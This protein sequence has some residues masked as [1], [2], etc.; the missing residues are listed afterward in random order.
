MFDFYCAGFDSGFT[1]KQ[2]NTVWN[3]ARMA[4]IEEPER[5]F[6]SVPTINKAIAA[7]IALATSV[8]TI[9]TPKMQKFLE[10]V[11]EYRSKIELNPPQKQGLKN[12]HGIR[13][14]QRLRLVLPTHGIFTSVVLSN[15]GLITISYPV[16]VKDQ[17]RCFNWSKK[18][19]TV[20]FWRKNDAGYIF[21]TPVYEVGHYRGRSVLFL[22]HSDKLQRSQ[23]RKNIRCPCSIMADL[24]LLSAVTEADA[25]LPETDKGIKC[26]LED[27]SE[28]GALIR[29]GGKGQENMTIKIQ[30]MLGESMIVMCGVV[31]SV[32]FN[33]K[34]NQSRLHFQAENIADSVKQV[35]AMYVY[36]VIPSEQKE[37]FD[38][39]SLV[40]QDEDSDLSEE[41]IHELE[42]VE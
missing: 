4:S 26:V 17:Y 2:M 38:A 8:D 12:T 33:E 24:Y 11:Y 15:E 39:L 32:E 28:E 23:K 14:G 29:I 10:S 1:F 7:V 41:E 30:F 19:V 20:Y 35:I 36:S 42:E 18:N 9:D 40:E 13:V 16:P 5:L 25:S 3:L 6:W 37:A 27:L 34:L 21:D 31:R 22:Q